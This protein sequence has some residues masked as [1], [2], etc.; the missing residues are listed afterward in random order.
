MR[1]SRK[2]GE[3]NLKN[4]ELELDNLVNE[5]R[6]IDELLPILE[7]EKKASVVNRNFKEASEKAADIKAKKNRQQEIVVKIDDIKKM[8]DDL[9]KTL[10]VD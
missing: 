6:Q 2:K 8:K 5:V 4:Y 1:L 10:G 9:I 7:K 3:D